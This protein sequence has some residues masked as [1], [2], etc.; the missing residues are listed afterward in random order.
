M[1]FN[2]NIVIEGTLAVKEVICWSLME[3]CVELARA[4]ASSAVIMQTDACNRGT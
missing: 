4:R 2:Y 3:S 1:M